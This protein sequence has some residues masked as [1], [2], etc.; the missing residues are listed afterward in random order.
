MDVS[1][2][3]QDVSKFF[4]S[5]LK[6]IVLPHTKAQNYVSAALI[7]QSLHN[8]NKEELQRVTEELHTRLMS[9]TFKIHQ[10]MNVGLQHM[11]GIA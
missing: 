10:S 11:C 1:N 6:H 2:M 5:P 7:T 3:S 8:C 9:R 4:P